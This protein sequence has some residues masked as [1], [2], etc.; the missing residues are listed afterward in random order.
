MDLGSAVGS[1]TSDQVGSQLGG[2][3]D[4]G[5]GINASGDAQKLAF[6]LGYVGGTLYLAQKLEGSDAE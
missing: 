6:D 4:K 5:G 2:L 3:L 1:A